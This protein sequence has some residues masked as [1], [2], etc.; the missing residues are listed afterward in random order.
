[1]TAP[2]F[3]LLLIAPAA[4]IDFARKWF[5][6]R[7]KW[8]Y[9]C[10][11]G[12]SFTAVLI[13]VQWPFATFLMSAA[14]RNW[15]FATN[16]FGFDVPSGSDFFQHHF[17]AFDVNGLALLVGLMASFALASGMA[18]AG[19]VWAGWLKRVQR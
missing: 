17:A 5:R 13:L 8:V 1:M 6:D 9:A 14:S 16:S 18:A 12:I 19:L 3:P 2:E 7:P 4:A 11:L 10:G 15:I